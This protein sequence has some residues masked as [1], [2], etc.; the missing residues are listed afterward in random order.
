MSATAYALKDR[1]GF[2]LSV[3]WNQ[4]IQ[5]ARDALTCRCGHKNVSHGYGE[6]TGPS[7]PDGSQIGRGAC[8]IDRCPCQTFE[9]ERTQR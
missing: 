7:W 1:N 5:T 4:T 3:M 8:G 6:D 9:D 2:G